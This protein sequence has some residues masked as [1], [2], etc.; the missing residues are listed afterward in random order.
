MYGI[1]TRSDAANQSV[2]LFYR[3]L[4]EIEI[5]VEDVDAEAIY[6]ELL[7]RATGDR[8]K[9]KKVISLAGREKVVEM[10][11]RY[12]EEFPALFIID[13]DLDLLHDERE[14][15]FERLFQHRLYCFENYLIC[16]NASAEL[17]R[18]HSGR[19][20]KH[21]AIDLLDWDGFI[22][23]ITPTLLELF[24]VYAVSWKALEE[25]R[26]TTVSRSYH[27]MCTQQ[28][29]PSRWDL[30]STKVQEVIDEIKAQVLEV[31]TPERYQ[32]IYDSVSNTVA[33]LATPL[34][35][36]SGKD[37]LLKALR[38]YLAFKG[39]SYSCDDGFKFKLARYCDIEPLAELSDA[40]IYTVNEGAYLQ[41]S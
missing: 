18:D 10:C 17:L 6:T 20:L 9:I 12:E 26:I 24:K 7:T 27:T 29:N 14:G 35:A 31:I 28:R 22:A 40:I 19:L 8:V 39:A 30:C 25:D 11:Q 36:I 15:P 2:G 21:Q 38:E 16:Q 33:S 34:C 5:Y 41:A 1:P 13:G 37:Y 3:D 23:N 32:E 4:Q